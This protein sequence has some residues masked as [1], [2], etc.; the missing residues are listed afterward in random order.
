MSYSGQDV[1]SE[2]EQSQK[3]TH[4]LLVDRCYN[5]RTSEVDMSAAAGSGPLIW[6]FLRT[7]HADVNTRY[8]DAHE[9]T[10]PL[11]SCL[12]YDCQLPRCHSVGAGTL[13]CQLFIHFSHSVHL[14]SFLVSL[15]LPFILSAGFTIRTI[16]LVSLAI[17]A[18]ILLPTYFI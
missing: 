13:P 3:A 17:C 18:F 12:L 5:L 7:T 15:L 9:V 14:R 11:F 6:R 4:Q 8:G 2:E 1:V 16:T 10:L